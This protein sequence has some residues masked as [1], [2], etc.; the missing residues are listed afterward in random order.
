MEGTGGFIAEMALSSLDADHQPG[1]CISCHSCEK[2]CPQ[3]I[4]IPEELAKFAKK[5]ENNGD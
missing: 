5:M 4:H 1:S 2:V 3:S